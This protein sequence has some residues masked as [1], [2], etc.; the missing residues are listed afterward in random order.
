MKQE[1]P[2]VLCT[3]ALA[4]RSTPVDLLQSETSRGRRLEDGWRHSNYC[5][6]KDEG[7][8]RPWPTEV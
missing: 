4:M 3:R 8:V 1:R 2:K 7:E 5:L 6:A